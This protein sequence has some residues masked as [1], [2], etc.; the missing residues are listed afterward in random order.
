M[1]PPVGIEP[2]SQASEAHTLSIELRGRHC[3]EAEKWC[4]SIMHPLINFN[5]LP[6]R[7]RLKNCVN[8]TVEFR[9]YITIK[10]SFSLSGFNDLDHGL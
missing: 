10:A 8:T 4:P 3:F 9:A 2:T 1:V 6:I 5:H 7:C